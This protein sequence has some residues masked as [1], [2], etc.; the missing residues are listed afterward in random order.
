MARLEKSAPNKFG[1]ASMKS[2]SSASKGVK[3]LLIAVTYFSL[4][5]QEILA[6]V[7][8]I[9]AAADDEASVISHVVI[10]PAFSRIAVTGARESRTNV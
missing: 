4:R 9:K 6:L 5:R 2:P 8:P 3:F 1:A 10:F 7:F